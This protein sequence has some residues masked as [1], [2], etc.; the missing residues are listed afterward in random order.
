MISEAE[1]Q[2][3]MLDLLDEVF[4]LSETYDSVTIDKYLYLDVD[5]YLNL[6]A[7]DDILNNLR[8]R[9]TNTPQGKGNS[10]ER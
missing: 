8:K 9:I 2:K 10:D 4:K 7:L 5:T 3:A 1:H 6:D